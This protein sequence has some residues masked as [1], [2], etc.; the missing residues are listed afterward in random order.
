MQLILFL[1][2]I[3]LSISKITKVCYFPKQMI[4]K[5]INKF[6][7]NGQFIS[8]SDELLIGHVTSELIERRSI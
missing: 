4:E 2:Q 7:P 8:N 3:T 1:K 5:K 6:V